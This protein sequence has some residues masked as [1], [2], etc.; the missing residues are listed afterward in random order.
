M[1]RPITGENNKI[2]GGPYFMEVPLKFNL[3]IRT[4]ISGRSWGYPVFMLRGYNSYGICD[5]WCW[6]FVR[7]FSHKIISTN[8]AGT[9]CIRDKS[10]NLL[11]IRSS[12]RYWC[13]EGVQYRILNAFFSPTLALIRIQPNFKLGAENIRNLKIGNDIDFSHA[14][15]TS[16]G[17]IKDHRRRLAKYTITTWCTSK[18]IA[19]DNGTCLDSFGHPLIDD[20]GNLIGELLNS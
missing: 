10:L 17:W 3:D 5:Y 9:S 18:K 7:S 8:F 6:E 12:S 16:A 4:E 20:A 14:T 13:K 15:G 11:V 2:G 19:T 1:F